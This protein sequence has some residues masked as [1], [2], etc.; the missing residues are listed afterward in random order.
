M[1]RERR[2]LGDHLG[3]RQRLLGGERL[4]LEPDQVRRRRRVEA[5]R[6]IA[7]RHHDEPGQQRQLAREREDQLRRRLVHEVGV[8]DLDQRPA[9]ELAAQEAQDHLVQARA[10]EVRRE[11]LDLAAWRAL[12]RR[13]PR[14][15]AGARAPATGRPRSTVARSRA[16]TT[17]SASSRPSPSSLRSSSLQVRTAWRPCTARTSHAG[18]ARPRTRS[19]TS[20]ISRVLPMPGSLTSSISRPRPRLASSSACSSCVSSRS[21]PTSGNRTGTVSAR[22]RRP[23]TA[24][25]ESAWTGCALPLTMNGCERGRLEPRGRALH[26]AGGGV[27]RA[28][29]RLGHQPRGE[30]DHV[31][32]HG[33]GAAVPG[34]DVAGEE[35][36]AVDPDAH[37]DRRVPPRRCGAA[38]AACAP[39]RRPS[40]AARPR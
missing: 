4:Q 33:V 26:D 28:R 1:R 39:P 16:S 19:R 18:P 27:D 37:G 3:E 36:A 31:A 30:V 12:P 22:P 24:P 25:T 6:A 34:S 21:R 40:P 8:L 10:P 15:A 17:S 14:R 7:P 13:R 11:L 23:S 35:R 9:G 29:R 32:H 38:P 2:R 20:S 5:A